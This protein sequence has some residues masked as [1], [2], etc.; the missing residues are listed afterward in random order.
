MRGV[1][2]TLSDIMKY[3]SSEAEGSLVSKW[4]GRGHGKRRSSGNQ[5]G[6]SDKAARLA[7]KSVLSRALWGKRVRRWRSYSQCVCSLAP[8]E[9]R[10]ELLNL[11]R[12]V[13]RISSLPASAP[14]SAAQKTPNQTSP[15]NSHTRQGRLHGVYRLGQTIHFTCHRLI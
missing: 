14:H 7:L 12:Y 1:S 9:I 15:S 11:T 5:T 8:P 2:S 10:W 13:K 4:G 6:I 3:L